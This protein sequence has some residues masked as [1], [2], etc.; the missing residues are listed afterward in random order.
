M[1][2]LRYYKFR[3]VTDTI[4]G[5][6]SVECTLAVQLRE[7]ESLVYTYSSALTPIISSVSPTR[8]G[9]AGGTTITIDGNGF[10]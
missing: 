4:A 3:C 7:S 1:S 5:S 6:G 8:G 2:Q 9:S 10:G